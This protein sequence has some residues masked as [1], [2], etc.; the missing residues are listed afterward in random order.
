MLNDLRSRESALARRLIGAALA[1]LLVVRLVLGPA[2]LPTPEPGLVPL[3]T[4]TGL[5][6]VALDGAK[7]NRGGQDPNA[8]PFFGFVAAPPGPSLALLPPGPAFFAAPAALAIPAQPA[9]RVPSRHAP[10]APPSLL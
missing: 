1:L 6:Y 10:R 7:G 8:C 9:L 4:G 2:V 5:V 3:C